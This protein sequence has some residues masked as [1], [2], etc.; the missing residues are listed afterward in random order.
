[1]LRV[2]VVNDTDHVRI[3][4]RRELLETLESFLN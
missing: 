1:M 2:R 4:Y 3:L